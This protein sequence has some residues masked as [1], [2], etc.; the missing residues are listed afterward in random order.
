MSK[1]KFK[2]LTNSNLLFFKNNL[3]PVPF[4][5]ALELANLISKKKSVLSARKDLLINE[6]GICVQ[7]GI[8]Q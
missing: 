2:R 8:N 6:V 1:G 4:W 7:F 5:P 3:Q